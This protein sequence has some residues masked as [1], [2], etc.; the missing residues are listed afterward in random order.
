M[1][2]AV[3]GIAMISPNIISIIPKYTKWT[4]AI[5]PLYFYA[6][7]VAIASVTSPLTN[8]F[9]ATGKILLTT[10]FMIMWTTL[11]W[12]LFPILTIKYGIVGTS[13]ATV[14]VGASSFVVWIYAHR[15]FKVNIIKTVSKPLIG[16]LLM[17]ISLILIQQIQLNSWLIFF[18]KI[19][20]GLIIYGVYM[21]IFSRSEIIWFWHQL[22][23]LKN[24]K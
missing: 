12:I 17:M 7:N 16:S 19:I 18:S 11:T 13:I 2:P 5:L 9:N 4:P 8:A 24:K 20:S 23:C 22:L 3:T 21:I 10:K 15:L 14:L 1:F 6:V